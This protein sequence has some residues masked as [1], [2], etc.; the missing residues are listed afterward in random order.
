MANLKKNSEGK[1][2]VD[3]TLCR[4]GRVKSHC[5]SAHVLKVIIKP[6]CNC[7]CREWCWIKIIQINWRANQTS[8][9]YIYKDTSRSFVKNYFREFKARIVKTR[10]PTTTNFRILKKWESCF[11]EFHLTS[12]PII[13]PK[14]K[15]SNIVLRNQKLRLCKTCGRTMEEGNCSSCISSKCWILE[16]DFCSSQNPKWRNMR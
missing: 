8:P 10:S 6:W 13:P 5:T 1:N 12:Q 14:P 4:W 7:W 15:N 11:V 9:R 16:I 2:F 3:V